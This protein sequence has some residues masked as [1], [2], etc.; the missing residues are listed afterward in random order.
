MSYHLE[1]TRG[2]LKSGHATREQTRYVCICECARPT[3]NT[4]GSKPES[5]QLW[6]DCG[7]G[8]GSN[9]WLR[10]H[11]CRYHQLHHPADVAS[12][13]FELCQNSLY[14]AFSRP[15]IRVLYNLYI[16]PLKGTLT[17]AQLFS[18]RHGGKRCPWITPRSRG[19]NPGRTLTN[20]SQ[21]K[22]LA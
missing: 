12:G 11:P 2:W 6:Y 13:P 5:G 10:L 15:V 8:R 7:F 14:T 3:S 21:L 20:D 16:I 22:V 4:T 9:I 19:C 18:D 1:L 17:L